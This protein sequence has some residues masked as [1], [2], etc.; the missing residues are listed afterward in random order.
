MTC[1]DTGRQAA[2]EAK[3]SSKERVSLQTSAE[4]L[5][6]QSHIIRQVPDTPYWKFYSSKIKEMNYLGNDSLDL[7]LTN[8][9]LIHEVREIGTLG[10]KRVHW[11][12]IPW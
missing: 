12:K 10:K 7:I 2:S 1:P 4:I 8:K 5:F 3:Q 9:V 11:P 6:Q